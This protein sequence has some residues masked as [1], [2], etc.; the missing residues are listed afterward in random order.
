M[1]SAAEQKIMT[2]NKRQ[3][4]DNRFVGFITTRNYDARLYNA[5]KAQKG[6]Q[7]CYSLDVVVPIVKGIIQSAWSPEYWIEASVICLILLRHEI[8]RVES[9]AF[10]SADISKDA[11]I[12]RIAITTKSSTSAN[13]TEYP[14]PLQLLTKTPQIQFTAFLPPNP[15]A[16]IF[17]IRPVSN[18]SSH[19]L[20]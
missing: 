7:D 2:H 14:E 5:L 20:F 4:G 13:Q 1:S 6:C 16:I 17:S 10:L 18:N 12:A 3:D 9:T 15:V 11:R 19:M 8:S